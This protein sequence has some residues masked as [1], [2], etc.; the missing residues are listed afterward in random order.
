VPVTFGTNGAVALGPAVPLFRTE[1]ENNFQARQ[2]YVL[3]PDGQRFLINAP[4]QAIDPPSITVILN[5]KGK[6]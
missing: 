5:W 6:P 1:F 3:S 2:Q 4:T